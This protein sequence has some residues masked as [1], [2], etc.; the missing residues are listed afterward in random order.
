MSQATPPPSD[1]SPAGARERLSATLGLLRSLL[2]YRR[3]GR[4]RA[5]RQ[6]YRPF[7]GRDDLVFDIGAHMGD[8]TRAFARLGGRVIAVEP[9]PVL[10]RWLERSTGRLRNVT[11]RGEA[12]GAQPG[13]A[14]LHISHRTPTV[15]TLSPRW[16]DE[17]PRRNDGFRHVRW[18]DRVEVPVITLDDLIAEYGLPAF[19][20]ID[21][22]GFELEVLSGLSRPIPAVS[23]EFV[24]GALDIAIAGMD[25]L[26]EL[27]DYEF[28]VI[29]G[30]QRE[31]RFARWQ[32]R[33]RVRMWLEAHASDYGS[34]DLYARLPDARR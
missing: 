11:V 19:C 26:A 24:A 15:S 7:I 13:T 3:P 14:T 29:S 32:D 30:E 21:A 16:T 34:G 1:A 4:Q 2:I 27:G 22:E 33:R 6:L 25:R 17:L 8:R 20:K 10:R 5:L 18:E 28:N 12:V 23:L 9:Q 31:Y